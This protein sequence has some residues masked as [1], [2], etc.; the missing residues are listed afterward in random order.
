MIRGLFAAVLALAG[1][2]AGGALVGQE[3]SP[4][5]VQDAWSRATPGGASV[6]VGYLKIRNAG[7]APDRLAGVS[8]EI[9][10]RAEIHRSGTEGTTATMRPVEGLE[11]GAKG[12][13]ELRP[14]GDHL[15][16]IGLKRPLREGERFRATLRFE[17]AGPIEAEFVVRGLGVRQGTGHR[18]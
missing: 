18:H 17:R 6:G 11:I 9:A 2:L 8:S 15:M 7:A 3:G 13:A 4:L 12:A 1:L 10:S 5:T 16:F 14:G